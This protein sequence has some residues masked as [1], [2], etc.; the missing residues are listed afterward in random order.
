MQAASPGRDVLGQHQL[1][2][3]KGQPP[4]EVVPTGVGLRDGLTTC[5]YNSIHH[6]KKNERVTVLASQVC[7]SE[8]HKYMDGCAG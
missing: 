2:A 8:L 3:A 6:L 7:C 5:G 4:A 1:P